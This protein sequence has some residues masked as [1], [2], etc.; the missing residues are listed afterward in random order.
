MKN[1]KEIQPESFQQNE[2]VQW[3]K[4]PLVRFFRSEKSMQEAKAVRLFQSEFEKFGTRKL[5]RTFV[6]F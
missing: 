2:F 6:S 3:A 1:F 4:K 5:R